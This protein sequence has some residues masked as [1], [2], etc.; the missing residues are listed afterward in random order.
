SGGSYDV[1][2]GGAASTVATLPVVLT[3]LT[4]PI[5]VEAPVKQS[6]NPG[7]AAKFSVQVYGTEPLSYQWKVLDKGAT[8]FRDLVNGSGLSGAQSDSLVLENIATSLSGGSYEVVVSNA[9]GSLTT[10]PVLLKTIAF[11]LASGAALPGA[12]SADAPTVQTLKRGDSFTLSA[13][14]ATPSDDYSIAYQWRVNGKAISGATGATFAI[15]KV[16]E[17]DAGIYDVMISAIVRGEEKGRFLGAGTLLVVKAPPVIAEMLAQVVRPGQ[18]AVVA[19]VVTGETGMTLSWSKVVNGG[20]VALSSGTT[21]DPVSG[22]LVIASAQVTDSGTYQLL[23]RDANGDR[24]AQIKVTVSLPITVAVSSLTPVVSGTL[25]LDQRARFRLTA[26]ASDPAATY[27]W[28]FNG[29]PVYG[30]TTP[31]FNVTSVSVKHAGR[32]DVIASNGT[33]RVTSDAVVLKVN[34]PLMINKQPVAQTLN[35]G[36]ALNLSVG[37]NLTSGVSFQWVKGVGRAAQILAGQT[38]SALRIDSVKTADEGI[39]MVLITGPN[40]RLTSTLAKVTVNKPVLIT[41]QPTGQS[42]S[43]GNA[44]EFRV[45]VTGTGPFSYQ[46]YRDGVAVPGGTGAALRLSSVAASDAGSYYVRVSNPVDANG[47]LSDTA[48]LQVSVPASI[49]SEPADVKVL[50][51]GTVTLTVQAAGDGVLKYQWRRNGVNISNPSATTGTLTASKVSVL[52]TGLYDMVVENYMDASLTTQIGRAVSRKISVQVIEPT[53]VLVLPVSQTAKVGN[54]ARFRVV[55]AGSGP[56]QYKWEKVRNVGGVLTTTKLKSSTDTYEI[57]AVAEAD[58]ANDPDKDY[59]QVT[60]SG[61][62]SDTVNTPIVVSGLTLTAGEAGPLIKTQP[63][64]LTAVKVG[65]SATLS[66][67]MV[68]PAEASLAYAWYKAGSATVLSTSGTLT[69]AKTVSGDTGYYFAV[70]TAASGWVQ[71][72]PSVVFVNEADPTG[73]SSDATKIA[74]TT[75]FQSML[76][77]EGDTVTLRTFAIGDG[78][79]YKWRRLDGGSLTSDRIKGVES[80]NLVLRGVVPSDGSGKDGV[81]YVASVYSGSTFLLDLAPWVLKVM[82][83]PVILSQPES[84]TLMPGQTAIFSGSLLVTSDTRFQWY[85]RSTPTAAWVPVPGATGGSSGGS[86]CYVA[87]VKEADAGEYRLDVSN[88]AGTV[89]S[90]NATLVVRKPVVVTGVTPEQPSVDPGTD[91]TLTVNFTGDA[92]DNPYQWWKQNAAGKW[93]QI[94][95]GGSSQTLVLKAVSETDD[96]FYKARVFGKVN[97]G[98]VDSLPVRLSVHDAVAL[99]AGQRLQTTSVVAGESTEFSVKATGWDPHYEW[100]FR[101]DTTSAWTT[102]F[103]GTSATLSLKSIGPSMMSLG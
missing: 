68:N 67:E 57:A 73:T 11:S 58:F 38:S 61:P 97:A 70:V 30:A 76:A 46:W 49:V 51:G 8:S 86:T 54:P 28:R 85:F 77:N 18:R 44:V 32:Y 37:V 101:K 9:Y 6:V 13:P 5:L 42:L 63:A 26:Q 95:N 17:A 21:F 43:P 60:I 93:T 72:V 22:V 23:A 96:A 84:Q 98:G 69:L 19:P 64:A 65:D 79:T 52:D 33:E 25:T 39:Y 15:E 82:P 14:P 62:L 89:S 71:S 80:A 35:P 74:S 53:K 103:S 55:A 48:K 24:T 88:T 92:Q 81:S 41:K 56:L 59:Y 7:D 29:T 16:Q 99:V 1:V 66:I 12:S 47:V 3:V 31:I 45:E 102:E 36:Q 40:G 78:L 91:V 27:Q 2:I 83:V 87:N 4:K 50:Q 75:A 34:D 10:T 20:T 90:Q 100:L 94:V